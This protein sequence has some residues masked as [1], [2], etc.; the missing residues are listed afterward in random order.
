MSDKK[1]QR[2]KLRCEGSPVKFEGTVLQSTPDG[3]RITVR[4]DGPLDD[5]ELF[6]IG[7]FRL[8]SNMIGSDGKPV[9]DWLQATKSSVWEV[10]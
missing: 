5:L 1:V 3:K 9:T 8:A 10:L 6:S 4:F 2:I 7:D